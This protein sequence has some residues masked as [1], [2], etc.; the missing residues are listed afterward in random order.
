[1]VLG[2]KIILEFFE[3]ELAVSADQR[4]ALICLHFLWRAPLAEGLLLDPLVERSTGRLLE[5]LHKLFDFLAIVT[6]GLI[7]RKL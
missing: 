3:E 5:L 2:L 7:L 4:L 6:A 1:M